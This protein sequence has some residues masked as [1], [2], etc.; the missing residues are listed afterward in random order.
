MDVIIDDDDNKSVEYIYLINSYLVNTQIK[1]KVSW[2]AQ[3]WINKQSVYEQKL[4]IPSDIKEQEAVA[5]IL[6]DIDTS[7]S[8]LKIK[9]QKYEKIK[10]WMMQQLLTWKI[11]LV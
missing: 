8:K 11:R 5:I 7:I 2:S 3:L 6:S 10:Q 4:I 1:K 9:K